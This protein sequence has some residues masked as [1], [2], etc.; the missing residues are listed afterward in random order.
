LRAVRTANEQIEEVVMRKSLVGMVML[1]SA[2]ALAPGCATKG[3]VRSESGKV[4]G[5]VDTVSQ[6]LEQTQER[7]GTN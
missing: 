2:V 7:V 5:K 4:N 1:A 6:S 3:F